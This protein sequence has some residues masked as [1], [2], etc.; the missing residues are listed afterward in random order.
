MARRTKPGRGTKAVLTAVVTAG[1]LV[2]GLAPAHAAQ[3]G[4]SPSA[5]AYRAKADSGVR[6]DL[7]RTGRATFWVTLDDEATLPSGVAART[8][9]ER[10]R[11]VFTAKRAHAREAQ[12]PL[13]ALLDGAGATY[14]SFWITNTLKVT[15]DRD[16]ARRI[17]ARPEVT[18]L[19]PDEAVSVADTGKATAPVRTA[20]PAKASEV[21]KA[22]RT[23]EA[24]TASEN[25]EAS[26]ASGAS[27]AGKASESRA[28]AAG[29][30]A[31]APA[32]EAVWN[33]ERIN[34]P[35]V[36]SE[37]GVRG[38]GIVVA[39]IGT[40]VGLEHPALRDRY[41]GLTA[42]GSY[43]HAYSWYDPMNYCPGNAP[44]DTSFVGTSAVGVMVGDNGPGHRIG[45]APDA[46][47]IAAKA[48]QAMGCAVDS[49]L[50]AGQWM[51]APTDARGANPRPDLA[52]HVV[53]NS[54]WVNNTNAWFKPVLQAWRDAGIFASFP[55][56]GGG[57]RCESAIGVS[58]YADAYV[59]TTF[60]ADGAL[61]AE[62]ARGS[63]ENGAVKPNIAAPGVNIRSAG[64]DGGYALVTGP[65]MAASHTA[66]TVA[67]LWSLA[68][69]L[70]G[71]VAETERVLDGSAIDVDDTSCGGTPA[72][73]NVWGE[74]KLDARAA[75]AA[76]PAALHGSAG[77]TVTSGGGPLAEAAVAFSGP[78]KARVRS[79]ASGA[80]RAPVLAPGDYT[81]TTTLFGYLSRTAPITVGA[82]GHVTHDVALD[83]APMARLTG[84]VTTASEPEG[85]AL[86]AVAGTSASVRTARDGSWALRVPHG[87]HGLTV[88]ADHRCA[89]TSTVQVGV[90]GDTV[91]DVGLTRRTDVFGTTCTVESGRAFPTGDTKL[92]F[93]MPSFS[94]S[95]FDLPFPVPFYGRTYRKATAS[96]AGVLGFGRMS[97]RARSAPLPDIS[98]PDGAVY[99]FWDDLA[100]EA[101]SGVYWSA[102]GTAPHRTVTVEWRNMR[103]IMSNPQERVSF[104]V[105][106]SEDGT[107]S[108]HYK[109]VT[110]A[111]ANGSSAGIGVE[112]ATGTDALHYSNDEGLLRDGMSI[113]YRTN[114]AVVAGKVTDG[115]DGEPVAGATVTAGGRSDTTGPDGR[116]AFQVPAPDAHQVTVS[117]PDHTSTERRLTVE[118]GGTTVTD[119][120]LDTGRVTA[121]TAS[122]H[123]VVPPG[124]R[125][126]RTVELA[127]SGSVT[128]YKIAERGDQR[129]VSVDPPSGELAA[130]A[131]KSLGV[132]FDTTGVAPGTTLTGTLRLSTWSGRKPV[133]D[134]P[135]T[136]VVPAYRAAVD[137]GATGA[138]TDAHGDTWTPD[139]AYT[140][141]SHGYLG[142][143]TRQTTTRTLTGSPLH[144]PALY[145]TA[146][147]GMY[148]YRFDTVPNGTYRVELGFA[149]L[150]DQRPSQR[151]F[152]VMAEG[153]LF[154]TDLDPARE[155]GVRATHD[156]AFTVRVTD[157]QLNLRFVTNSGKT[158]VNSVRVTER[159]DL[160][161]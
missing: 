160:T 15:A 114:S 140:A 11:T 19:N 47:W 8:K 43:E 24:G 81:V 71:K 68:P 76:I 61:H 78:T 152:D 99:A 65:G 69:G 85:N 97:T 72:D 129:W 133:I 84:R 28:A 55:N 95:T 51:I 77:G 73:N 93:H 42:D 12:A 122:L 119:F 127:N 106:V 149:E 112:N 110:G 100:A 142:T 57:P 48:C 89:E 27:G 138:L 60:G 141:G 108:S 30:A 116:Y 66:G 25:R 148:E 143:S 130:G 104:S 41:R 49:I 67:L 113:H 115:N 44:C 82:G 34:A 35:R 45:V 155:A 123:L 154:V 87:T 16:L 131:R 6:A 32:D 105:V 146:R 92:P 90:T 79:D 75:A 153:E 22:P 107:A 120:A 58:G 96:L 53:N 145:R 31:A 161:G 117:A 37:F 135:V 158:L 9:A 70:R 21:R 33:I 80:Y 94:M 18:A 111:K 26:K 125:R 64:R 14:E 147:Q 54:W 29:K 40:G 157:G 88:T 2:L 151:V 139:R 62:S 126:V 10:G 4:P 7:D 36:W 132:R 1:S 137:A 83:E 102:G 86:V 150:A 59:T 38:E 13:K 39:D 118:P 74:G 50:R 124:E 56:D 23:P 91:R 121:D 134:I 5:A 20:T 46:D 63:G 159:S 17:A 109:N 136:V 3:P 98:V 52:P 103:L 101:D 144:D 128:P 156:R